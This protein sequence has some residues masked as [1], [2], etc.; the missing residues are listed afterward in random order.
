MKIT[1]DN[2][3]F[4]IRKQIR[5]IEKAAQQHSQ[6]VKRTF[7]VTGPQLGVLKIISEAQPLTL[8]ELTA[9]MGV[10]ITTIEGI[11]NRLHKRQL[12]HKPRNKR[13]RRNLEIS[14]TEKGE[15]LLRGVPTGLMQR[16]YDNLKSISDREARALHRSVA[17]LV[18][19]VGASDVKVD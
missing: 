15:K 9:K 5:K 17:R 8:S 7:G 16:L 14:V 11:V 12:V 1:K 13:D 4:E 19:L 3:Y 2:A 18:E 6:H 10:H